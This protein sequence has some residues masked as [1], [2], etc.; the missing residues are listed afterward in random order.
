M[1]SEIYSSS[2]EPSDKV[3]AMHVEK[4]QT[5]SQ[6]LSPEDAHFLETYPIEKQKKAI[7]KVDVSISQ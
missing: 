1:S 6:G 2:V 3:E 7:R 4:G 5:L